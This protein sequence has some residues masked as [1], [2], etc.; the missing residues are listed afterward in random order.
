LNGIRA[1]GRFHKLF[2]IYIGEQR[3]SKTPVLDK[4][5]GRYMLGFVILSHDSPEQVLRLVDRLA[6]LYGQPP[7]VIHHDFSK[8]ELDAALLPSC[9]SVVRPHIVTARAQ[10]S[11]V[12]ATVL[13]LRG[14]YARHDAPDWFSVISGADYPVKPATAVLAELRHSPGD[15]FMQYQHISAETAETEWQHRCVWRYFRRHFRLPDIVQSRMPFAE[16]RAWP[17]WCA[18]PSLPFSREFQCY[19]GSQWFTANRKC[20]ERILRWYDSK[21]Q[22]TS[23]YERSRVPVPDESY[24]QC[25]LVND[26]SLTIVNDNKRYLE[27]GQSGRP[28]T[29]T[30]QDLPSIMA[31]SAHFARKFALG[32]A[33]LD[34][35]D[36]ILGIAS[37]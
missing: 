26:T 33:V 17:G 1:G 2:C 13:G 28:R 12:E 4:V 15:A 20:A 37:R 27:W 6:A 25:V 29:L 14:L 32:D 7:I 19:A 16:N 24:F 36:R 35:L 34:D 30:G 31:S 10:W 5:C 11:L 18:A 23:H 22:L 3:E 21:N 8:S 9:A